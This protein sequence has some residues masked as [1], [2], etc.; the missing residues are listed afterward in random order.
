[1]VGM[2]GP[3]HRMPNGT[4]MPGARHGGP[5]ENLMRSPMSP[6]KPKGAAAMKAA[7]SASAYMMSA[8]GRKSRDDPDKAGGSKQRARLAKLQSK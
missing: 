8:S 4:V 1:M 6:M 7:P 3:T 5:M 2:K